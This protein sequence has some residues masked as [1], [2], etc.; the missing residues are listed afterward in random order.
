M[1]LSPV[2]GHVA[3]LSRLEGAIASGRFPQAA[4]FTGP[5]GAGKQRVALWVAQALLCEKGPGGP[6]GECPQCR[7]TSG[8]AHPDVHWF[9]PVARPKAGDLDKQ[10]AEV[11]ESLGAAMAERRTT[12]RWGPSDGMMS[13]S[14]AA[15]RLL[16]RRVALTPFQGR[17]KVVILG[18]AERLVVQEG[19]PEAANALLKVLEEPPRDTTLILTAAEPQ[20]LLATIRSR[21]V[22]V[23][24]GPVGDEAVRAFLERE[25]PDAARELKQRILLAEGCIGKALQ[26]AEGPGTAGA[27][28]AEALLKAVRAG[29]A[30]WSA[31]A[32]ARAP[33]SARG[34][35]SAMLDALA[36]RLR[37][38]L[39]TAASRGDADTA[40]QRASAV[41]RVETARADAQGNLNPQLAVA[42]LA[43]ELEAL[44]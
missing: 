28:A 34:D 39:K 13:H 44:V 43:R 20:A 32:L 2:Y 26:T 38:E 15:V 41:R 6:C 24:V 19:N 21:T 5:T 1:S 35:F 22:A 29:P 17:R 8:L 3:L 10:I 7:M 25:E 33:W 12:G 18:D 37:G 31:T 9:V 42:L 14:L 16:Q 23:R 30:A 40:R 36:V 27:D 11:E 4:L